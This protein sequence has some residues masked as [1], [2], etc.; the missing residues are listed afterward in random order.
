MKNL[1]RKWGQ[2][3]YFMIH[4]L[5]FLDATAHIRKVV[6]HKIAQKDKKK[7][8]DLKMERLSKMK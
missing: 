8:L 6:Y 2:K 3:E 5:P 7:I 1:C 4:D